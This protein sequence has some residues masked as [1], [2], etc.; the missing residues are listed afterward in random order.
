M[1]EK[2]IFIFIALHVSMVIMG[3]FVS[4]HSF[5]GIVLATLA[6]VSLPPLIAASMI[7]FTDK[8]RYYLPCWII[9]FRFTRWFVLNYIPIPP[10]HMR[11]TFEPDPADSAVLVL[12]LIFLMQ[13]GIW[14][15]VKLIRFSDRKFSNL[16][17]KQLY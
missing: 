10:R 2:Y 5:Y 7:L 12:I 8:F 13:F 15:I 9:T 1:K 3:I 17:H 14:C 16:N 11:R 6:F 4:S